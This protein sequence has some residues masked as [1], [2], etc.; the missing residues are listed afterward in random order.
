MISFTRWHRSMSVEFGWRAQWPFSVWGLGEWLLKA[1]LWWCHF[2]LRRL[3]TLTH[4]TSIKATREV[5]AHDI[6]IMLWY[7]NPQ[8]CHLG[9]QFNQLQPSNICHN[10]TV[11]WEK[12]PVQNSQISPRECQTGAFVEMLFSHFKVVCQIHAST[13]LMREV[14]TQD[15]RRNTLLQHN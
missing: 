3:L 1:A 6:I 8:R 11:I 13:N 10:C 14:G 12:S 7:F 2:D 9:C 5:C 4:S 15:W